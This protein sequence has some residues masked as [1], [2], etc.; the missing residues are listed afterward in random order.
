MKPVLTPQE[1]TAADNAAIA[2]GTPAEVL[3]TRAGVGG[4]LGVPKTFGRNVWATSFGG[5]R[6]G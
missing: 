1:M 5:L 3:L 2:A 6:P 4:G